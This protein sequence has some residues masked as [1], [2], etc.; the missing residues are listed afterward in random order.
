LTNVRHKTVDAVHWQHV[1][2]WWVVISAFVYLVTPAVDSPAQVAYYT[3]R[4]DKLHFRFI[5]KQQRA[6]GT[7]LVVSVY[8]AH[9][10]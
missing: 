8:N 10:L 6:I 3:T 5:I 7:F 2:T 9:G 1:T 4:C